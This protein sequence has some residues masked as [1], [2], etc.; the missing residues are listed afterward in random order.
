MGFVA[1]T[2]K[3]NM[4]PNAKPQRVL[5]RSTPDFVKKNQLTAYSLSAVVLDASTAAVFRKST[6]NTTA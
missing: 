1:M 4:A 5:V 2:I 3:F 6:V